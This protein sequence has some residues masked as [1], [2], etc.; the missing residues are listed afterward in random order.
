[1]VLI[2]P[3][4]HKKLYYNA[5]DQ[6][7]QDIDQ[8]E[9]FPVINQFIVSFLTEKDSFYEG[10]YLNRVHF[11]PKSDKWYHSWPLW[12]ISN[13]YIWNVRKYVEPKSIVLELGCASGVDYFGSRYSMMGL[14]LSL[15]SLKHLSN[16]AYAI[17]ADAS[18]LPL[19]DNSVDAIISSYFWEH[20]LPPVKDQMLLEFRRVLKPGGNL[21]FLFDVETENS[22]INLL[23]KRDIALYSRLFLEKDGHIG[24]ETPAANKERFQQHGFQVIKHFG[25]ERTWVQSLSVYEKYRHLPGLMGLIGKLG[26]LPS[27]SR[28]T[29]MLHN[30]FVRV[31]DETVGRLFSAKKSRILISV[32]KKQESV[33]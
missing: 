3:T 8:T 6:I 29:A 4:S 14:D 33:R 13:G 19:Q 16:Y 12:L 24:Y 30:L 32:L 10:S 5:D 23:K 28:P 9:K 31:I 21:V 25:M 7:Y 26:Y 2:S 18:T 11:K 1:M 27:R 22:F 17:Q 20:I 15:S